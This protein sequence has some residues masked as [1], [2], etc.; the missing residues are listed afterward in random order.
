MNGTIPVDADARFQFIDRD[1]NGILELMVKFS[2]VSVIAWLDTIY[3]DGAEEN[4]QIIF[5]VT[6][7]VKD[8]FFKGYNVLEY[9][10]STKQ[11]A[12]MHGYIS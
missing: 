11:R 4:F 9:S 10:Q 3:G 12:R 1:H 6:G 2:K 7:K 5:E 8:T